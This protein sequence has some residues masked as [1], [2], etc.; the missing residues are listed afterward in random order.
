MPICLALVNRGKYPYPFS[1]VNPLRYNGRGSMLVN[2]LLR[3]SW[4][5]IATHIRDGRNIWRGSWHDPNSPI[6][7]G[8]CG[9]WAENSYGLCKAP[10]CF[11]SHWRTCLFAP[12][13]LSLEPKGGPV[14][15]LAP[16][17][18]TFYLHLLLPHE[19]IL[20]YKT[21]DYKT[22]MCHGTSE[23]LGNR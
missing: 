5:L 2:Q 3:D 10:A 7:Q 8:P 21:W 23:S 20:T 17:Q 22:L 11:I 16:T 19:I 1:C 14:C 12:A 13:M 6:H 15:W 4:I 9:F 18:A